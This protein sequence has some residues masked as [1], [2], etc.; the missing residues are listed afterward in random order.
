[1]FY[2]F[3]TGFQKTVNGIILIGNRTISCHRI[4]KICLQKFHNMVSWF[5][6]GKQ[7]MESS[8]QECLPFLCRQKYLRDGWQWFLE[9]SLLKQ[10][11]I[12]DLKTYCRTLHNN[13]DREF[14]IYLSNIIIWSVINSCSLYF[15]QAKSPLMFLLYPG[16]K[17]LSNL[18]HFQ[19]LLTVL[20][21]IEQHGN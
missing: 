6:N 3:Q 5:Q 13:H 20:I 12:I 19:V 4:E 2:C 14:I 8:K 9:L 17:K 1:M 18:I 16:H 21:V 15:V 10:K 7:E 11:I